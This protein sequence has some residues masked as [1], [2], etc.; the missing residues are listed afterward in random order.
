[1]FHLA[2]DTGEKHAVAAANQQNVEIAAN[3]PETQ[4]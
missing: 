4:Q 3:V 1:L 2:P